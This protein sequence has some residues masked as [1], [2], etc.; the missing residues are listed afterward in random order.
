MSRALFVIDV[1]NWGF[2]GDW[3]LP[4]HEKLLK[5]IS[6]R[7]AIAR[8]NGEVIVHVQN[9]GDEGELDAPGEHF[10]QLVLET[11][12]GERVIRKT[13]QDTFESNTDLAADLLTSGVTE[14]ELIGAQSEL[15]VLKT[16]KG[17]HAAGF[18]VFTSRDL[19]G[20]YDG[21]YPGAES[22]PSNSELSDSTQQQIEV[23]N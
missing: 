6:E 16:A 5:R 15:C 11:H 2:T 12:P 9:D 4:N 14:T 20:T 19:H 8:K 1:Q 13:T 21:G 3:P 17:A 22:G 7:L 10:W 18:S 23:L